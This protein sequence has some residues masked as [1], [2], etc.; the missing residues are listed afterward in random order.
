MIERDTSSEGGDGD[1]GNGNTSN[2]KDWGTGKGVKGLRGHVYE[3]IKRKNDSHD[4]W[5]REIWED[6]T[7]NPGEGTNQL[8]QTKDT[9]GS[10]V[11][12]TLDGLETNES[13]L[14]GQ[15][16]SQHVHCA[17]GNIQTVANNEIG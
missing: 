9:K 2:G 17:I 14:H 12:R 5:E 1:G 13:D 7:T 10:H 15:E 11:L 3:W 16:G 6:M 4:E 8:Q